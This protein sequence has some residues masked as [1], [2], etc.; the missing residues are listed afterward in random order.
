MKFT[1]VG[2]GYVGL[3]IATLLAIDNKVEAVDIN[4]KRVELIN[5]GIPTIED[6]LIKEYFENK[7]NFGKDNNLYATTT[8][9]YKE[10]DIVII[11]VPTNY[12]ENANYFDTSI[13][14]KVISE[15][16]S[17]NKNSLIVIKSTIPIGFCNRMIEK[18]NT[19][20]IVFSPEFLR[21]SRALYDNLYP[22]RIIVGTNGDKLV[23]EKAKSFIEILK[24]SILLEDIPT[25]IIGVTEAESVKLFS[26]SYL[27]MRVS[28]FN[29]LD[30]C[31]EINNLN[32]QEI[33]TGVCLEPRIGMDY[34]NPSF[35][36]GGYC[37]PKDTK[38]L[39]SNFNGVPEN[40]I[41]AIVSSNTTRKE[42]IANEILKKLDYDKNKVV[43]VYRLT[44]K[45]NSDN[46]RCSAIQDIINIIKSKGVEVIIYE[47]LIE[48]TEFTGCKIVNDLKTFTSVSDI[49]IANR[50]DTKLNP[51]KSKVYTRD[52]FNNN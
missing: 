30:T 26:N 19:P 49:I 28:Y 16:V 38:Q 13:V 9:N 37:F 2:T 6:A 5:K 24:N 3:S 17:E 31:S 8:P 4:T 29:E 33:I 1:V 25:M 36:Y 22:S 50:F 32:S 39:L 43:G 42:F 11:A 40:I 44:M 23:N 14:E 52:I 21:E 41:S 51:V 15:V 10:S 45:S 34:N 20:N 35:G 27:A 7:I 48:D 12:D 47:P 46:F 18:Y